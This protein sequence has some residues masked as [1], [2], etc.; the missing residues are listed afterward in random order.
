M[1][2]TL[3]TSYCSGFVPIVH[4]V[5]GIQ[6]FCIV[7]FSESKKT[8]QLLGLCPEPRLGLH[9]RTPPTASPLIPTFHFSMLACMSL[10]VTGSGSVGECSRLTHCSWLWV[11]YNIV[12]LIHTHL[13]CKHLLGQNVWKSGRLWW[14]NC[15]CYSF[16]QL[17]TGC[18]QWKRQCLICS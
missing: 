15:Q 12:I 3:H 6:L 14:C 13:T 17:M 5:I 4:D 1:L 8:L 7:S 10:L 11:H 16:V 9:R 2:F 18:F